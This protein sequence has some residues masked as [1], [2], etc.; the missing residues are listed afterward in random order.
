MDDSSSVVELTLA[1]G[2]QHDSRG[3]RGKTFHDVRPLFGKDS[4]REFYSRRVQVC[5]A[6]CLVIS[7]NWPLAAISRMSSVIFIE[8]YFGPHM[9]QKWAL[10]NV[11]CG[12]V[13]S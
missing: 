1:T 4:R 3:E 11:S 12:S 10:L 8:Q 9:L 2:R 6:S 5:F 7:T 13:S